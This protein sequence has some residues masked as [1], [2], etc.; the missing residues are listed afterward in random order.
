MIARGCASNCSYCSIRFAH[1]NIESTNKNEII[2]SFHLGLNKGFKKF[3]LIA[4]DVGAYGIDVNTNIVALLEEL[5]AIDGD[6]KIIIDD[7]NPHWMIRYFDELLPLLTKYSNKIEDLRIPIQSGS[8]RILKLMRR[9][10]TIE[11]VSLCIDSLWEH[12]P[13]LKI[14]THCLVGFPGE[15]E[16]D[17]DETINF[18]NRYPKIAVEIFDYQ[19]RFFCDSVKFPGKVSDREIRKRVKAVRSLVYS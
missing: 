9:R 6:F 12:I 17:F 14:R 7:F 5:F 18:L 10:Y 8:N 2:E 19:E 15:T 16:K 4:E 1:G 11:E 3:V 13:N